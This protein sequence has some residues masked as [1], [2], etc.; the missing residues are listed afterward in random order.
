MHT[1]VEILTQARLDRNFTPRLFFHN[2]NF[3]LRMSFL[4]A[5]L[6]YNWLCLSVCSSVCTPLSGLYLAIFYIV[7]I[8]YILGNETNSPPLR[9]F[10]RWS[11]LFIWIVVLIV[12]PVLSLQ[13][14]VCI[15]FFSRI[16]IEL[17]YTSARPDLR[18]MF[19]KHLTIAS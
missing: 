1:S 18:I 19:L 4:G 2:N 13:S 7:Y 5:K 9:S 16:K 14:R 11:S 6:L 10:G 3:E 15:H 17:A 8:L 12:I